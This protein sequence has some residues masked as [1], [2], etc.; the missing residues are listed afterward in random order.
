MQRK[1]LIAIY[2]EIR[3]GK[4]TLALKIINKAVAENKKVA[5]FKIDKKLLK[6]NIQALIN[7]TRVIIFS[8]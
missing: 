7:K 8:K 2:G 1:G 3:S 4:T 5:V 6:E